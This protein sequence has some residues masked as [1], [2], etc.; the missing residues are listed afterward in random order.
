MARKIRADET[1]STSGRIR[2]PSLQLEENKMDYLEQDFNEYEQ[3]F[4]YDDYAYDML[5]S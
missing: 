4:D 1:I 2:R 5:M 3:N